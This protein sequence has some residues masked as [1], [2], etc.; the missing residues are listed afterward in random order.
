MRDDQVGIDLISG[1]AIQWTVVRGAFS[2]PEAG[3]ADVCKAGAELG[4]AGYLALG[5]VRSRVLNL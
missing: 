3:R 2:A 5:L 4:C 1:E